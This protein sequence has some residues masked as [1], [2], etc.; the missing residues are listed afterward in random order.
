MQLEGKSIQHMKFGKGIVKESGGKYITVQ[1][2][3]GEK[4]FLYPDAFF[5]FLVFNDKKMQEKIDIILDGMISKEEKDR[6]A[7]IREQERVHKIQTLKV[8]LNSQAAFGMI[9]NAKENVF[10]TW[11]IFSGNYLSGKSKGKPKPPLKLKLNSACLLTE[12]LAGEAESKRRI[13]GAFMVND[14]FVGSNCQDGII[15]SHENFR[16]KLKTNEMLSFW[17]Y[18]S[19]DEGSQKWGGAEM[20]YF[21]NIKMQHILNDIQTKITDLKRQQLVSEF[22]QYFCYVNRL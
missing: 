22:Y 15:K 3:E 9:Q 14:D 18:F 13:I 1:F 19:N 7:E 6:E 10:D 8:E 16:I 21:T 2:E 4:Q 20:K 11:T 17:D 12:C 5:K